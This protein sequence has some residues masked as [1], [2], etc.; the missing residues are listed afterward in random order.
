MTEKKHKSTSGD[1]GGFSVGEYSDELHAENPEDLRIGEHGYKYRLLEGPVMPPYVTPAR[2]ALSRSL[3]T[4]AS[5][6]CFVS[7]PKSSSTWLSYILVLLTRS[8]GN[9]CHD[10]AAATLRGSLH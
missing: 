5:D 2:Y 4:R 8:P 1:T 7:Y 10:G 9:L 6:V 3:R